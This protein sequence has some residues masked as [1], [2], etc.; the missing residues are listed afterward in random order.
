MS[1]LTLHPVKGIDRF[2]VAANIHPE[3]L[4][5]HLSELEPGG[6]PH[7]L[8]THEGVEGFYILEG[9]ATL[10]TGGE[11]CVLK[12]NQ[13]VVVD[14]TQAHTIRNTGSQKVRYLVVQTKEK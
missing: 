9:E 7:G 2:W 5:M 13:A 12:A 8:H 4:H 10:D 1:A 11:S 3:K 14:A 6:S